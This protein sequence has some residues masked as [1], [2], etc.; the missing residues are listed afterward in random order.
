MSLVLNHSP[1]HIVSKLLIQLGLTTLPVT[2]TVGVWPVHVSNEP[3]VPDNCVT[4]YDTV[5]QPDGR[6]MID[7]ELDQ[8]FGFQVRVRSDNFPDGWAKAYAIQR[9]LAELITNLV[10]HINDSD[11]LVHCI[12]KIGIIIHFG[13][14]VPSN[15]RDLFTINAL[16]SLARI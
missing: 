4:I 2:G 1:A 6:S 12:S 5:G 7:G 14:E 10:V 11:Y 8:H 16:V 15:K 9:A 13:K 3:N